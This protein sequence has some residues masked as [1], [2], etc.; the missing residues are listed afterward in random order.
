LPAV[1]ELIAKS[2]YLGHRK[3]RIRQFGFLQGD[4]VGL[5]G[6]EPL[7]KLWQPYSQ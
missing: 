2:L 1:S 3:I 4:D 6:C 5:H 7:G